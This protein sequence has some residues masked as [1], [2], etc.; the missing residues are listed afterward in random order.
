MTNRAKKL[1][2][3]LR[4]ISKQEHL[5]TEEQLIELK[6]NIRVVE[7]E[8]AKKEKENSKGFGK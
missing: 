2:N 5:Y 7:E 3:L 4:R 6:N 8:I 1:L